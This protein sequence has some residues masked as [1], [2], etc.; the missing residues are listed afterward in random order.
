MTKQWVYLSRNAKET[1]TA[2]LGHEPELPE[3]K[4][5]LGGKGAGLAAMT[6]SGAPVPPSFTITT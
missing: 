3:M 4:V 5:I 6:V 1:L 2:E